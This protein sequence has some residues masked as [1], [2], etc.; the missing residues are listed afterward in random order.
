MN[1]RS[2]NTRSRNTGPIA[3]R[4]PTLALATTALIA[5]LSGPALA[6]RVEESR[7]VKAFSSVAA[8][9]SSDVIIKVGPKQSVVVKAEEGETEEIRTEVR[10]DELVI[11]RES[12][13]GKGWRSHSAQVIITMPDLEALASRGSG[14]A[15]VTGLKANDFKLNQQGSGDVELAGSCKSARISS[16]GSGD[17]DSS[18]LTCGDVDITLRGSGDMEV[19]MLKAADVRVDAVGSGDV[20]LRGTC[21]DLKISHMASGDIDA[22]RLEC[23]TV[24]VRASGSGDMRVFASQE[25]SVKIRGSGDVEVY[26]GAKISEIDI[27]GSGRVRTRN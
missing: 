4:A 5:V 13:K 27:S 22:H 7:T 16:Q 12:R 10:G 24:D 1:T 3:S 14:D 23:N 18:K 6:E 20:T 17:L 8:N 25:A 2:R 9:G 11:W 21:K 19:G 15:Y 26:G